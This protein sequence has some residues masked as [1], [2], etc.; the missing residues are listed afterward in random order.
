MLRDRYKKWGIND[1]NTR[2]RQT[3]AAPKSL[4]TQMVL[5]QSPRIAELEADES[6]VV[7][8]LDSHQNEPE[9]LDRQIT[10]AELRTGSPHAALVSLDPWTHHI[11]DRLSH[12][13]DAHVNFPF[14]RED[15]TGSD[16]VE[17][18]HASMGELRDAEP[19]LAWRRLADVCSVEMM[20]LTLRRT[21]HLLHLLANFMFGGYMSSRVFRFFSQYA[22]KILGLRHPVTLLCVHLA[23]GLPRAPVLDTME[24]LY[25]IHTQRESII[26]RRRLGELPSGLT[27]AMYREPISLCWGWGERG[28]TENAVSD[29]GHM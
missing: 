9:L 14:S 15:E 21:G 6:H 25:Q 29:R 28:S 19:E 27:F 22:A 24:G 18:I 16:C 12:W 7:Q 5:S 3:A 8:D 26:R 2:Q 13:C 10:L 17:L 4:T 1:K 20:L 23:H 11:L